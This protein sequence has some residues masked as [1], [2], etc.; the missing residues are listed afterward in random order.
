MSPL[1]DFYTDEQVAEFLG[2]TKHS[3]AKRRCAGRAHPPFKKLGRKIIYPKKE[4]HSWLN[5]QPIKKAIA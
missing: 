1:D 4:F 5:A 2:I 3:L